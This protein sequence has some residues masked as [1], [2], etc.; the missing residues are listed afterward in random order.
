MD[1]YTYEVQKEKLNSVVRQRGITDRPE[2]SAAADLRWR[3]L[4]NNSVAVLVCCFNL[5]T[6]C[7]SISAGETRFASIFQSK[8][9]GFDLIFFK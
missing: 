2:A 8:L 3:E 7:D 4:S 1:V 5:T 6:D 9:S